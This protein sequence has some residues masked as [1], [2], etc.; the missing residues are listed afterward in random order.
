M[1]RRRFPLV[2]SCLSTSLNA[3][4][5]PP[6]SVAL[7]RL[8]SSSSET[9]TAGHW[10]TLR[11]L[12]GIQV[13]PSTPH[14]YSRQTCLRGAS[15][16]SGL[17]R[18]WIQSRRSPR[19]LANVNGDGFDSLWVGTWDG[20]GILLSACIVFLVCM[21]RLW[22]NKKKAGEGWVATSPAAQT[23]GKIVTS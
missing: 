8:G 11:L 19:R 13:L 6:L 22:P 17:W 9:R 5:A 3:D 10:T 20:V 7:A 21:H 4:R 1:P 18:R 23:W 2:L 16:S 12:L 14:R 15:G